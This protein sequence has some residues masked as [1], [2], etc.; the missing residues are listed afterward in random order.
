MRGLSKLTGFSYRRIG[1]WCSGK[2]PV[3]MDAGPALSRALGIDLG[4]LAGARLESEV[5]P[6]PE[7]TTAELAQTL[8]AYRERQRLPQWAI[9]AV[10]DCSPQKL[11]KLEERGE[12]RSLPLHFAPI[13]A[14]LFQC[15]FEELWAELE[16]EDEGELDG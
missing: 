2:V 9:A 16:D 8:R 13:L 4:R 11:S 10:V 3:P 6:V 5:A 14:L 12:G 1:R 15:S 7:R